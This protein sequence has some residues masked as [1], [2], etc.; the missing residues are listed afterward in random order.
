MSVVRRVLCLV[1]LC[2]WSSAWAQTTVSSF[3]P[4]GQVRR[5]RQAVARFSQPMVAFGDLRAE[6]PFDVDCAV[7]GS[8]RWV[9]AQTW[10]YDFERDLPGATACRFT[11]KPNAHDLAGQP[12]AGRRAYGVATG[13]PAVLKSLPNEGESGIDEQQAFVLALSA[14]ATD[15]S[16]LKQAW[17]R[18]DGVNEKIGVSLLKGDERLQ[19][20]LHDHW[21]VGQAAAADK[22]EGDAWSYSEA[23]LRADEKAGRLRRLVVL[24]CRRTLPASTEVA[25]VWGAGVAA[26]NG[27]ATDRDQ[28]L[29]F[30]TRADF[31]A[32][33]NCDK[34]NARAQCIP[35]LPVRVNFSAPS[36]CKSACTR[37]TSMFIS[38][39][40]AIMNPC[41]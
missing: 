11:L 9:D 35:F 20:L 13:G 7:P 28:T 31:T 30:K 4:E 32:R 17:C 27:I 2:C 33:F 5:V 40:C 12:L 25:L 15:D 14:P 26:P 6:S 21:F 19:A 29:K 39:W 36:L 41:P 24:Q 10:S 22:G 37:A 34:V 8:G 16:I 3:S 18:A 23:K 1:L 38:I